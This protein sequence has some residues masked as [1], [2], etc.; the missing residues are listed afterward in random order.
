MTRWILLTLV[1]VLASLPA[2]AHAQQA[3]Q[4]I[5]TSGSPIV[6]VQMR[7]GLVRVRTWDKQQVQIQSSVPV[8]ARH[9]GPQAVANV[10][11]PDI[12][13]FSMQV[14]TKNGPV[15]LPPEDFLLDP[16]LMIQPHDGVLVFGGDQQAQITLTIPN[17]T[18][19]FFGIVGRGGID[20]NGYRN[21]TFVAEVHTGGVHLANVTGNGY[22]EVARG[23][24]IVQDSAFNSIRARTAT[25]NIIF[26]N[27][28]VRQIEAST[29]DGNVAYDNGTFVPGIARLESQNGDVAIGIAGGG[30]SIAA[31]SSGGKIFTGFSRAASVLG[32]P[33]DAQAVVGGG[34]PIVTANSSRGAVYLY[35]GALQSHGRLQGAWQ[36]IGRLLQR[37]PL[38][39]K[40]P[41][42]RHI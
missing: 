9:V 18:A 27:C 22:A 1:A 24:L 6:R 42:R 36:T 23:P 4:L 20:I 16:S 7:S 21:G 33:T 25:G 40:F 37:R 41:H 38:Q 8:Q 13:I 34:G 14:Q 11:R 2:N 26:E 12:P 28:N 15:T 5:A 19:L 29:I 10:L 39:Q 32:S 3:S 31:H 30:A 17:S 35:D